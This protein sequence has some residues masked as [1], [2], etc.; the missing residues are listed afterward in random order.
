MLNDESQQTLSV[1]DKCCQIVL[2]ANNRMVND[3]SRLPSVFVC[4][5]LTWS[6]FSQLWTATGEKNKIRAA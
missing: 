4:V 5:T 1:S 2:A 6:E 3:Y